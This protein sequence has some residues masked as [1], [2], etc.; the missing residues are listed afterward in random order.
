MGQVEDLALTAW[1]GERHA[2][3]TL[4][5]PRKGEQV[6]LVTEGT[7]TARDDLLKAAREKGIAEIMVPKTVISVVELPLLGTGK[8]DYPGVE[9]LVKARLGET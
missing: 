3:I 9:A 1:P 8:T 6:I 5:D 4:P 7:E 2:A